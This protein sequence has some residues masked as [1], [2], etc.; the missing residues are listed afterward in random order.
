MKLAMK[1]YVIT[2]IILFTILILAIG[3]YFIYSNAKTNESNSTDTLK[4]K[5]LAEIDYL[6]T[7]IVEIMNGL[8]NISFSNFEI[9]NQKINAT[10]PEG[11]NTTSSENTIDAT[12]IQYDNILT[13]DNNAIDWNDLKGKVENMY[14][15]WT[16]VLMDLTTLNVNRD[17][18]LRYNNLLDEVVKNLQNED[19]NAS[20]SNMAELYNLL[21][22]YVR[23][24]SND[25]YLTSLY[26]VKSNILYA[27]SVLETDDWQKATE[28]I[29][30]A[31]Q[32]FNTI[33]NNQMNNIANMDTINKSYILLNELAEDCNNQNKDIFYVNY[34]NLMQ[35]L[36]N[37]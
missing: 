26:G 6:S 9:I 8:N 2:I 3:G 22:L 32:E 34:R 35:E 14:S 29:S 17:N 13:N 31:R 36:E 28:Y 12:V 4:S 7:E 24:F 25:N 30:L 11:E 20:L 33:M 16:S 5:A 18:L 23:D 21:N 37:T 10:P 19:K 15:S 1:K 27:Y